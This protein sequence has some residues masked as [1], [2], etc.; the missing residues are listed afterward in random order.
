MPPSYCFLLLKHR[1]II[2][3]HLVSS[4]LCRCILRGLHGAAG[5]QPDRNRADRASRAQAGPADP[6]STLGE[7][8]GAGKS[9]GPLLHPQEAPPLFQTV[10]PG[11]RPGALQ[12]Q[13]LWNW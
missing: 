4:L 12:G 3:K 8:L 10:L 13:Q 11:L 1:G 5:D 6:C 7:V 9:S 2:I